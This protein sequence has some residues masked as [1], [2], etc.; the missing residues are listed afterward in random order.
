MNIEKHASISANLFLAFFLALAHPA[1]AAVMTFDNQAAFLATVGPVTTY[2]FEVSSGFPADTN[3]TDVG[4][5][6][7]IGHFDGINFEATAVQIAT[8]ATS[9]VQV[10]SA[11]I[12][13]GPDAT[14][15][16]NP[17]TNGFGFFGLDIIAGGLIRVTVDFATGPDRVFDITDSD[18]IYLTPEY[19]G[20]YDPADS[21]LSA[22]FYAT[23][24]FDMSRRQS[25]SLDDLSVAPAV[26]PIPLPAGFWLFT[27]AIFG[28][29]GVVSR[30][31]K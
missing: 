28:L 6:A 8:L 29:I 13:T 3:G 18:G 23:A 31:G 19:F 16:F 26:S 25:W 14:L 5:W 15:T 12:G 4:G 20:V 10:M 7:Y 24:S 2:D 21:I 9:G 17:G 1:K 27:S 11:N 30:T 22:N